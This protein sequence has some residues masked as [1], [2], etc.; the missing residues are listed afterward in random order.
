MPSLVTVGACQFQPVLAWW[1]LNSVLEDS[2]LGV[3][4]YLKP[5]KVQSCR[6]RY[7]CTDRAQ[8][9]TPLTD[10]TVTDK[11]VMIGPNRQKRSPLLSSNPSGPPVTACRPP[12]QVP[13]KYDRRAARD[14]A[15]LSRR[16]DV[17][18]RC[19]VVVGRRIRTT[20]I[21]MDSF[22]GW[23]WRSTRSNVVACW[24]ERMNIFT[25]VFK[26]CFTAG[27]QRFRSRCRGSCVLRCS[28]FFQFAIRANEKGVV[29]VRRSART[30]LNLSAHPLWM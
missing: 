11:T 19:T 12:P 26:D 21:W 24:D 25:I 16:C 6:A 22:T 27:V 10:K 13:P 18:L 28:I 2:D 14:L 5:H 9:P 20:R 23:N 4:A 8:P 15:H 30:M 29:T 1:A 17:L 7:C 3:V